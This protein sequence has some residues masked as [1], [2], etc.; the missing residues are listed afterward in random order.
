MAGE[1]YNVCV[2]GSSNVDLTA[3]VPRLPK[4][5]ETVHGTRFKQ[6]FGGKG[7]NQC[8]MVAKLGGQVAMVTKVGED[9]YGEDFIANY[10]RH[11]VDTS[12]TFRTADASTGMAPIAVDENGRNCIIVI[13]GANDLLTP[14]DVR[15]SSDVITA[16]RVVV[17]QMEVPQETSLEALKIARE[18]GAVTI[19]NPAPAPKPSEFLYDLLNYCDIICPN[20]SE[21]ELLSGGIAVDTDEGCVAAARKLIEM[22]AKK[23]VM[24][25]GERGAL[26]VDATREFRVSCRSVRAVDTSGAGDSFVGAMSYFLAKGVDIEEALNRAAECATISVTR[27]GTQASYPVR[28]ELP[29][30][31]F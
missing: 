30:S 12:R 22:G 3:Y 21:A 18:S 16:A 9:R 27:P 2:V 10:R 7:A 1:K 19:L 29:S 23:V 8:V 15:E 11:G 4:P 13:S 5:G 14:A 24:T 26:Y 31:W 25:L 20:E 6:D 28:T 17:C